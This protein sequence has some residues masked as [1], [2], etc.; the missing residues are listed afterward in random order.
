MNKKEK[1]FWLNII[2]RNKGFMLLQ[3]CLLFC[4]S[5][6]GILGAYL[7][8]KI[9]DVLTE[10]ESKTSVWLCILYVVINVI[11]LIISLGVS[12]VSKTTSNCVDIYIKTQ[13]FDN[14]ISQKGKKILFT[15]SSEYTTLLLSDSSKVS[16]VIN[17][18]VMPSLLSLFRAVGLIV[19]LAIVEWRLLV[20]AL[21]IQPIIML[22]Q[23]R[24]KQSLEENADIGREST[25]SFIAAIKEYTSH[26]FEI[27]MLK[28]HDYF[29]DS[30]QNKLVRQKKYEKKIA[31]LEAK[32]DIIIEF[33]IMLS[34]VV[35]IAYGGYEVCKG[36]ITIGALMLYVQYYSGLLTPF[37]VILQNV[38]DYASI[39]PSLKKIIEYL[40]VEDVELGKKID[41]AL[42]TYKDVDFSYDEKEV[43]KNVNLK[44]ELGDTYGIFGES[45]SGK[46]TFCKLLVGFFEPTNGHIIYGSVDSKV[47]DKNELYNQV[48]YISQDGY[49]LNDTIY[50]NITLG[51][52]CDKNTFEQ[53]LRKVNLFD[54][55]N[56]LPDQENTIVGDNGALISGGQK[57]RIILARAI[58]NKAPIVI[59]DEPTTGLDEKNAKEVVRNLMDEFSKSLVVV[60]SHQMDIIELCNIKYRLHDKKIEQV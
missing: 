21:V 33:F 23:K 4:S 43:L 60:I 25:L 11:G 6:I 7:Y 8:M 16:E 31:M 19:F 36:R 50:N 53:I 48:C 37:G 46:S 42:I 56:E 52:E 17:G 32:N 13:L 41:G 54:F 30:F 12:W 20:I 58:L 51:Q 27:V 10:F 18:L 24:A 9:V 45:G 34:T 22:L 57:K 47:V 29:Y 1:L 59:L 39:R 14:I 38:F 28:K 2:K 15:D 49:L 55:V 26:L 5:G 40:H 3:L 35:I 44:L